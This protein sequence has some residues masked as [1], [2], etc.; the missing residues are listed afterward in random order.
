LAHL[1]A[2]TTSP[3]CPRRASLIRQHRRT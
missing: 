1:R 2:P 3:P